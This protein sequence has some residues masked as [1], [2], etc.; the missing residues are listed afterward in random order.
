V[1]SSK[2]QKAIDEVMA[3]ATLP[4][5]Y[6]YT[7]GGSAQN[8]SEIFL[9]LVLSIGLSPILIYMLLAA[10]YESLVLPFAVLL[11]QPL[12][13]VG[14][15]LALLAGRSTINLFSMI[16]MVLLI[17]LV[18]KN[19]IL[20]IDRTEQKR[21][22]GLSAVE[23]LAEA[24]RVRLRPILMT[25]MTLVVAMLPIALSTSPG[26]EFRAPLS[27]VLIGGMSSS[28]VLT[29]LIVPTLYTV[30][31]AARE[32]IPRGLRGLM[33]GRLPR[34]W[35]AWLHGRSADVA[36]VG[37]SGPPGGRHGYGTGFEPPPPAA[38]EPTRRLARVGPREPDTDPDGLIL[39]RGGPT[40]EGPDA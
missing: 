16:G 36:L 15:L 5:G 8:Q 28:T 11:A 20:L 3:A 35:S 21:R 38:A 33:R 2:A 37:V 13:V 12:A 19:G 1:A 14:A 39:L 32:R 9:P 7:I 40:P 6:S 23:A 18:S 10:L 30:L 17:G 24:G 26:S 22:E 4:A 25:S 27:L 34:R 29:M 31:D